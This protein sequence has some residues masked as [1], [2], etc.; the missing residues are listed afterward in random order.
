MGILQKKEIETVNVSSYHV[1]NHLG[2]WVSG[3][4]FIAVGVAAVIL[5]V[6]HIM[7]LTSLK[8]YLR[9]PGPHSSKDYHSRPTKVFWPMVRLSS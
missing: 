5:F 1:L 4:G 3:L 7:Q 8:K 2:C 6:L 9:Q